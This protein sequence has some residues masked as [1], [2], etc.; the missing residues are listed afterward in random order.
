MES[1]ISYPHKSNR[2]QN[3]ILHIL[4]IHYFPHKNITVPTNISITKY[5]LIQNSIVMAIGIGFQSLIRFNIMKSHVA[6]PAITP[7]SDPTNDSIMNRPILLYVEERLCKSFCMAK[8]Q[9]S[10]TIPKGYVPLCIEEEMEMLVVKA[11]F[12]MRW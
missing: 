9:R 5:A 2:N 11:E 8:P 1:S 6:N 4:L 7:L 3:V 10:G 12:I